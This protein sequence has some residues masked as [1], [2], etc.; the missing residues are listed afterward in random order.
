[1]P[2]CHALI[3]RAALWHQKGFITVRLSQSHPGI[4][5]LG[6]PPQTRRD[7]QMTPVNGLGPRK[8]VTH[9]HLSSVVL[10]MLRERQIVPREDGRLRVL[11]VGCGDGGLVAHFQQELSDALPQLTVEIHGFDIGE[12]GF[13]DDSQFTTTTRAL[14]AQVPHVDW[15]SRISIISDQDPWPYELGFF[16]IAISNQVFEHVQDLPQLLSELRRC[17]APSGASIHL[18]PL[19]TCIIEAHCATPFAHWFDD[20]DR[21]CEWIAL[22]SRIGVGSFRKDRATLGHKDRRHHAEQTASYIECWTWYRDFAAIAKAGSAAGLATS[23]GFTG[24][25]FAAKLRSMLRLRPARHYVPARFRALEWLSFALGQYLSSATLVMRPASYDIG[26]R[27]AAEK[28]ATA[29]RN[30]VA[31]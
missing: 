28:C 31:A 29:A 25:F 2:V 17:L 14:A 27:I 5:R 22:L 19:A 12:Q 26:R 24:R 21:R 13:R 10:T 1:M 23:S 30:N 6:S 4:A 11:D 16:D 15:G 18:F 20:Y 7:V 3:L 9:Q 8:S